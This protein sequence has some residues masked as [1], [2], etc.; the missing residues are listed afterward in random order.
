MACL[1]RLDWTITSSRR[2]L[3]SSSQ[4]SSSTSKVVLYSRLARFRYVGPSVYLDALVAKLSVPSLQDVDFYSYDG[5]RPYIE[6]LPP[7]INE[8]RECYHEVQAILKK[9]WFPP[10]DADLIGIHQPL[11]TT[12]HDTRVS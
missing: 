4:S 6:H 7:F 9:S 8:I 3:E 5:I 12:F 1:H 11:Q 2:L 10:F